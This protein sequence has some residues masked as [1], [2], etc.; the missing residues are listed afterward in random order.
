MAVLHP[1]PDPDPTVTLTDEQ[2]RMYYMAVPPFLYARICS[3][4]RAASAEIGAASHANPKSSISKS[5]LPAV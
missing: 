2:V 4:L 5:R 1:N 3:C